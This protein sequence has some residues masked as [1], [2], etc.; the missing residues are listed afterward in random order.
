VHTDTYSTRSSTVVRVP[1]GTGLPPR[2]LAA[3]GHPCTAPLLDVSGL[4]ET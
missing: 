4:F 3:D 2:V 1:A